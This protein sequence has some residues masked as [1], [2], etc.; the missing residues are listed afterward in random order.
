LFSASTASKGTA[1][2]QRQAAGGA[3][4]HAACSRQRALGASA[5]VQAK[6]TV[7]APGD[8]HERQADAMAAHVMRSSTLPSPTVSR[9]TS[10][11]SRK[12]D[13]ASAPTLDAQLSAR[14][15]AAANGGVP[16]P[17]AVRAEFEPR[18]R[19]N[20]AAVRIHH[21]ARAAALS[22]ALQ[23]RA[24]T[25]GRHVFFNHGEYAP[26]TERGKTLLAH[27]LTHVVQQ[28]A[29]G[30]AH[31]QREFDLGVGAALE[32]LAMRMVRQYAPSLEAL[33]R[34]GPVQWLRD[35]A[36]EAF[37]GVFDRV[38]ALLPAG[39][40]ARLS[41]VFHGLAQQVSLI[42]SALRTGDCGP[43]LRAIATM[44]AFLSGAAGAAWARLTDL[45][46]PI[47][48]FFTNLWQGFGAPAQ[49]ALT[50]FGSD[51][52]TQVQGLG[53]RIWSSTQPLR[54]GL[55]QAWS[56]VKEKLFGPEDV[57]DDGGGLVGWLGAKLGLAFSWVKEQTRPVWQPIATT[58]QRVAALVPPVFV[59][60]M[61]ERFTSMSAQLEQTSAAMGE[62]ADDVAENRGALARVLPSLEQVMEH[63]RGV[64]R[65]A[66]AWLR[67]RIDELGASATGF[68]SSVRASI[69]GFAA[70]PLAPLERLG[71]QLLHWVD[72]GVERMFS[73]LME[74]IELFAPFV[75]RLAAM[76]RKLID[77][78]ADWFR[79]GQLVVGEIWSAI[80]ACI[81]DPIKD[82]LV[83]G[84]LSNVPIFQTLRALPD[85]WARV[86]TIALRVLRQV[87]VDGQLARA[88]FTFFQAMLSAVGIPPQLVVQ[89]LAKAAGAIGDILT[90]PVAFLLN[91]LRAMKAGFQLFWDH[92]GTHLFNGVVGWLFSTLSAAGI[93][94]PADFSFRSILGL[95]MQ[96]LDITVNRVFERIALR[97]GREAADRLRRVLDLA[98]GAWAWISVLINEGPAGLWRELQERLSNL[99]D[100]VKTAA[101]GFLST[102]VINPAL[103]RVIS[104][105]DPTGI[106]AVVNGLMAIWSVIQTGAQALMPMLQIIN[107]VLDGIRGIATGAYDV[108][109]GFFETALAGALPVGI[110]FLAN[111]L[112]LGNLSTRIRDIVT[113]IRARVDQA[114]DWV[115]DRAA[116]AGQAVLNMI[117]R[118]VAAV[119]DWWRARRQFPVEGASHTLSFEGSNHTLTIQ[120]D[121]Q[122]MATFLASFTPRQPNLAAKT[123]AKSEALALLARISEVR[124]APEPASGPGAGTAGGP[125]K[126]QQISGLLD[127]LVTH[128][129]VL[130]AGSNPPSS[131]IRYGSLINAYGSSAE[132]EQLSANGSGGGEPG[133]TDGEW[134]T[135]T[136]RLNP[137]GGGTYYV[138]GHLINHNLWG[139]GN[140]W[141]NL[142]PITHDANNRASGSHL[143]KVEDKVKLAVIDEKKIVHYRVVAEYGRTLNTSLLNRFGDSQADELKKS[144]VRAEAKLPLRLRCTVRVVGVTR[145]R[146]MGHALPTIDIGDG[147]IAN[148]IDD[149]G[150]ERYRVSGE[151][152]PLP[153]PLF[154]SQ[155]AARMKSALEYVGHGGLNHEA[156]QR[157]DGA[158]AGRSFRT[159]SELKAHLDLGDHSVVDQLRERG[160][161]LYRR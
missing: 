36:S 113:R 100:T 7:S 27:E 32:A 63:V 57:S 127:Q 46:R 115:I 129:T 123:T 88:A 89:I 111:F 47:G 117:R 58:V 59:R 48:D 53:T 15:E 147:V 49:E 128:A 51:L 135:V 141:Q 112:R 108:A 75:R 139:P 56:W 130:L 125:G 140:S 35:R 138:R 84:I 62:E 4:A 145:P 159:W 16:L 151:P 61:G 22:T 5:G 18:F 150:P 126:A 148:T 60:E 33:L 121:P 120:S 54:D 20:F 44:R 38:T 136:R 93:T 97:V 73:L 8:A 30:A 14:I 23:A 68:V 77:V 105:L 116:R 137:D 81:R 110:R 79:I 74:G 6:L 153:N 50:R 94:P 13:T 55:G 154:F 155:I 122:P 85:V 146:D 12:T 24:F 71:G 114:L 25:R 67:P 17:G 40:L 19:A 28:G 26:T 144:I 161:R 132:C 64:V 45:V 29:A 142:T 156:A 95:V 78:A 92:I 149:S 133:V 90:N 152:P 66:R 52:W 91:L 99:W 69:L 43:L 34:S 76:V 86:Q 31:V 143:R 157:I 42:V 107:R 82:F 3:C 83:E 1:T 124:S 39:A 109:A 131:E 72:E 118:G 160:A 37:R 87:F 103:T 11:V 158:L 106:M 41:E 2:V 9:C 70:A 102:A 21:D 101:I 80:P 104:L 98:T 96:L 10:C 119:R 65:S 134:G